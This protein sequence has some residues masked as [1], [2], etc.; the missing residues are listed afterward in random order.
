M[1]S[2]ERE[3]QHALD[4]GAARSERF[5]TGHRDLWAALSAAVEGGKRFRPH[6]LTETHAALGGTEP[7]PVD[8]V[9]AALE[10][11]HTS[12][13]VHDDVIDG[14]EVRRGRLNVSGT[15]AAEAR[16]RGAAEPVAHHYGAAAG[17][18]A[19]DLA[20][21]T[22]TRMIARCGASPEVTENLLDLLEDAVHASA[23]GELADVGLALPVD[24]R[25]ASVADAV[26]VA[27]LKTAVYSFVLPLQAGAV[28]AGAPA[29][30]VAALAPVG[31][32]LGIGFQLLDDLLGVFGDPER[33]GKGT[34]SDLREGKPTALIAHARSTGAWAELRALVGN[35]VLDDRGADRARALLTDCG[36]RQRVT[37]L[38]NEF[39][40]DAL[41]A[42]GRPPLAPALH[43]VLAGMAEEIRQAA[44]S[45]LLAAPDRG[46]TP[47]PASDTVPGA[48]PGATPAGLPRR[49]G[50]QSL[51][52]R[53]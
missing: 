48:V 11:L 8:R 42:A 4:Q 20:L 24:G 17:L 30:A 12:F 3:I 32:H 15:F 5:G 31:R 47:A 21:I 37:A 38:A 16:Q 35:P 22:A 1:S 33:S 43:A 45:A 14:D 51:A 49:A 18:L 41:A 6:L 50:A 53:S 52:G 34:L 29:A 36:A 25:T 9:G 10:I 7:G 44:T 27:E 23:A 40:D 2:V 26:R 28:L 39:L 13:V 46:R 19:G